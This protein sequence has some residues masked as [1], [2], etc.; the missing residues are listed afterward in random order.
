MKALLRELAVGRAEA[1]LIPAAVAVRVDSRASGWY[2]CCQHLPDGSDGTHLK[3]MPH[4]TSTE[5]P[6]FHLVRF[7]EGFNVLLPRSPI[8]ARMVVS[9]LLACMSAIMTGLSTSFCK[10]VFAE[11]D[12]VDETYTTNL[13]RRQHATYHP[14]AAVE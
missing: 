6:R 7:S 8:V 11:C 10:D 14:T 13:L 12:A 5:V 9:K 4:A 2:C 1:V 3:R